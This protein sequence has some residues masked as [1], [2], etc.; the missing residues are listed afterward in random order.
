MN[1]KKV[2]G[3]IFSAIF[4]LAFTF[5]LTWGIINFNKLKDA[6]SGTGIYTEDD[7]NN[8]Y[9]DGYDKALEDKVS[10]DTLINS[11]RDTI[12]SQTDE[13]S[14][15]SSQVNLLTSSNNDNLTHITN[16]TNQK[17]TL[18]NQ[19]DNL[20]K[21]NKENSEIIENT[22]IEIENLNNQIYLLSTSSQNKQ[23]EINQLNLQ[24]SSLQ[25]IVSQL[26]NTNELNNNTI[27]NLNSQIIN[28]NSQISEMSNQIQNNNATVISLNNRISELQN[29]VLYYENYLKNLENGNQ[30]VVTFEFAGSVYLI[31]IVEKN[32]FAN[33]VNPTSTEYYQFN[34]W[35]VN[36]DRI[37]LSTYPITS[38]I[39]IVADVTY[40]YDVDYLV[41]DTVHNSQIVLKDS[42]SSI[43]SD[44][45]KD[46]Y[47]FDGW[48]L[49]GVDVVDPTTVAITNETTFIAKFTKLHNVSFMYEDT[50]L[51]N[52]TVRNGTVAQIVSV[53][54]TAYKHF[55]GWKL[56]DVIVDLFSNKI[57][58]DTT[59]VADITY[60]YD[61]NFVVDGNVVETNIVEN[62]KYSAVTD[63]IPTKNRYKF[64]GWSIDGVNVVD[65]SNFVITNNTNFIC[66]WADRVGF[67]DDI[68]TVSSTPINVSSVYE[69]NNQLVGINYYNSEYKV[70]FYD[71]STNSVESY[72][73]TQYSSILYSYLYNNNLYFIGSNYTSSSYGYFKFD[74][75][76]KIFTRI[77][78][79]VPFYNGVIGYYNNIM[80]VISSY[81]SSG[82]LYY[83]SYDLSSNQILNKL[84]LTKF[85]DNLYVGTHQYVKDQYI[86][87]TV[88]D[89]SL[90]NSSYSPNAMLVFDM[91]TNNF[92]VKQLETSKS[93]TPKLTMINNDIYVI[94]NGEYALYDC[95]TN[96]LYEFGSKPIEYKFVTETH[97]FILNSSNILIV[98]NSNGTETTINYITYDN[99]LIKNV[100]YIHKLS[101]NKYLALINISAKEFLTVY[102]WL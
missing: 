31:Q 27:N 9:Q 24:V 34:Y 79:E 87:L 16:L 47:E 73:G 37:E 88:E 41:D 51:S 81:S 90:S 66:V 12:T 76:T 33:V 13:I 17:N 80:T 63:I 6:M 18:E 86:C 22:N 58:S 56:N 40:S 29:S 61:V 70:V 38:N 21:I 46:G 92:I 20:T 93:N 99:K 1:T 2:L 53:D 97:K 25:N 36:G 39:K 102:L 82:N 95:N 78:D 14:K 71:L 32:T 75:E 4:V 5:V 35:T 44:P 89:R 59:F 54:S 100:Y 10:Y 84:N 83:G 68:I 62:G 26:Q 98:D 30:A 19:V 65:V 94:Y 7:V 3:I 96:T 43:P 85:N 69:Y 11:Y 55:N 74:L 67:D 101:D 28:L 23:E 60:S 77:I 72:K 42:Y 8:A 52:Q 57:Y 91:K 49:N 45:V 64:I 50:V 15:L 48:T